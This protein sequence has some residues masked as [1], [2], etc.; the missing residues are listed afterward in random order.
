[1]VQY[2]YKCVNT[3]ELRTITELL[4]NNDVVT[5]TR[6]NDVVTMTSNDEFTSIVG[7]SVTKATSEKKSR[8]HLMSIVEGTELTAQ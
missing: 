8:L 2:N 5:M 1:M 6:L 3:T 7:I 4:T